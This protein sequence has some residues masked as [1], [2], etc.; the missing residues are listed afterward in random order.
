MPCRKKFGCV[1]CS[2]VPQVV[3]Q[4]LDDKGEKCIFV[5][6]SE[7][8]KA[9]RLYNPITKKLII[10]GDVEFLEEEAWDG[11]LDKTNKVASSVPEEN[12]TQDVHSTTQTD[13]PTTPTRAPTTPSTTT[14]ASTNNSESSNPTLASLRSR[15]I[16][17]SR[18]TRSLRDIYDELQ[19]AEN[20]DS[21][22]K[23]PLLAHCDP[24]SFEEAIKVDKWISAMDEEIQSIEKNDTWDL[25]DFSK[26]EDVIGVQQVYKTKYNADGKVEKDKARL[27][28]KGFSQQ[29]GIDYNETFAPV[30]RLDTIRMI[31]SI[32]AQNNWKV[33][34]MDVKSAFL[35]DIL[36]KEL[37]I[38]QPP[39]YE[40]LGEE[41]KVYK[42]KKALY[43]LK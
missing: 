5:G 27:V 15:S 30:A 26:G 35:N 31:L 40:I 7:Q 11:T 22:I 18:K 28:A 43:G 9:Y 3:R 14:P 29:P 41:H 12:K 8:S 42:L 21:C 2:L 20:N 34:Q 23:F 6:Y 13:V 36:E 24:I 10:S 19:D 37:Y 17:T 4:K 33:Y 39:G 32:A 38:K 1:A 25:L 16:N